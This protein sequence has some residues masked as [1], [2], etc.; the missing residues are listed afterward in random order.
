[1]SDSHVIEATDATEVPATGV[2]VYD[3]W[4]VESLMINAGDPNGPVSATVRLRKYRRIDD[5]GREL[6]P[7][8]EPV[9]LDLP[10][11]FAA[12]AR[13]QHLASAIDAVLSAVHQLGR[14]R[15]VL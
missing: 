14:A 9:T 6:S 10:D 8:D 3:R 2:R 11:L 12:A 15:G 5:G 1:M 4:W 7:A 13:D